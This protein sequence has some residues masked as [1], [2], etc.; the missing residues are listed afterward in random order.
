MAVARIVADQSK[1]VLFNAVQH[2]KEYVKTKKQDDSDVNFVVKMYKRYQ[3]F[4]T[5]LLNKLK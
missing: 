2:W 5:I 1:L 3:S 4:D